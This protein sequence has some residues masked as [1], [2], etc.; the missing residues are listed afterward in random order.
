MEGLKTQLPPAKE[1]IHPPFPSKVISQPKKEEEE[2]K[3]FY[4]LPNS[5]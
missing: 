2:K 1:S 5:F 4:F 3:D